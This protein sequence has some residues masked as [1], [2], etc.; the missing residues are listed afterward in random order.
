MRVGS[1]FME[2]LIYL[3][4]LIQFSM[5]LLLLLSSYNRVSCTEAMTSYGDISSVNK[6]VINHY[7]NDLNQPAVLFDVC[8]TPRIKMKIWV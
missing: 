7:Y 8:S 5:L 2:R 3:G 1:K 6:S 4:K